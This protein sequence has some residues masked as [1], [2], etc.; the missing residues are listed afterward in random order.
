MVVTDSM[1]RHL[2]ALRREAADQGADYMACYWFGK[3][4]GSDGDGLASVRM[5]TLC[6]D[7]AYW[8]TCYL[9]SRGKPGIF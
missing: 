2:L 5:S 3:E 1:K 7:W 4:A 9:K 6:G 8:K